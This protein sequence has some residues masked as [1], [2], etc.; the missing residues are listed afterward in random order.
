MKAMAVLLVLVAVGLFVVSG[1]CPP[2]S[3]CVH[4]FAH[5]LYVSPAAA[6][7]SFEPGVIDPLSPTL[8]SCYAN[9]VADPTTP[10]PRA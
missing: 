2:G 4:S 9:V 10:P 5:E 7:S 6:T 8:A 1:L 3:D